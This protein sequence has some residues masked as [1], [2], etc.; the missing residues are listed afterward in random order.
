MMF[1]LY[2]FEKNIFQKKRSLI[3]LRFFFSLCGHQF[4]S[5][6]ICFHVYYILVS[7]FIYSVCRICIRQ[8]VK[9]EGLRFIIMYYVCRFDSVFIIIVNWR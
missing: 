7:V 8:T 2:N 1:P 4:T 6:T 9:I 3:R 5:F